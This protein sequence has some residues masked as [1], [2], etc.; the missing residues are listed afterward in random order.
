M[1]LPEGLKLDLALK[2]LSPGDGLKVGQLVRWSDCQGG[3]I[4]RFHCTICHERLFQITQET[5]TVNYECDMEMQRKPVNRA[6]CTVTLRE[7]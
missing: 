5:A 6:C 1:S 3:H 4:P 2:I 7:W